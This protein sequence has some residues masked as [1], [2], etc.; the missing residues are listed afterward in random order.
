MIDLCRAD[1]HFGPYMFAVFGASGTIGFGRAREQI[2][3]FGFYNQYFRT[4]QACY[5]TFRNN[6]N[7][8]AT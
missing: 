8:G 5:R 7:R 4:D 3:Q 6:N 2:Q 1:A